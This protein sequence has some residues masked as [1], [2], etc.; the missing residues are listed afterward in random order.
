MEN[1]LLLMVC[2]VFLISIIVGYMRGFLKIGISLLSTIVTIILVAVLTPKVGDTI[3]KVTPI[4]EMIEE[5]CIEA[6]MPDLTAEIFE[7]KDLTGTPFEG[8]DADQLSNLSDLHLERYGIDIHDIMNVIG[9]IPKDQQIQQ[10]E[11]ANIPKFL[12]EKLLENNNSTIYEIFGVKTFAEYVA[13]YIS[14]MIIYL[15]AFLVTFIIVLIIV[16]AVAVAIDIIG[17]LPVL[18]FFNRLA[19]AIVGAGS[20][21]LIVWIAFLILT[22]VYTTPLGQVAFGMIQ[23]SEFLTF[24]Y[25]N[26]L[27]LSKLLAF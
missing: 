4:D 14:R 19:G 8:L 23:E 7:G 24:L 2:G 15:M 10:I 9:E 6:L 3:I 22:L 13:T 21:L 26:N 18:G 16:K 27:L 20:G 12:K 11:S 5:R 17:E 25:E 1:W